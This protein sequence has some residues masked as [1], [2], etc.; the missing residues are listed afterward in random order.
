MVFATEKAVL[1]LPRGE[2]QK[3][4]VLLLLGEPDDWYFRMAR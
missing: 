2:I 3:R 1:G 4:V